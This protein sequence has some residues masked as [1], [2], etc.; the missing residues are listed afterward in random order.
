MKN[1][2]RHLG[3]IAASGSICVTLLLAGCGGSGSGD[4]SGTGS[5]SGSC[6]NGSDSYTPINAP[7]TAIR[8]APAAAISILRINGEGIGIDNEYTIRANN[9]A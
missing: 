4:L 3:W 8:I 9:T 2:F 1:E 5:G 7:V 6:N